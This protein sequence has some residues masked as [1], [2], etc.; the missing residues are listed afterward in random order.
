MR[1]LH[2]LLLCLLVVGA[3]SHD[4]ALDCQDDG[5]FCNG[6]ERF[7]DGACVKVPAAPCDDGVD[8]TQD[9][10][11]EA[12]RTCAHT[13]MGSCAMCRMDDCTPSCT[14]K[15]C[16][17]DG[18][19]GS[20]GS[21]GSGQGCTPMGACARADGLGTCTKPRPLAV[22]LGGNNLQVIQGD[23]TAAVHQSV[24]TCNSTSRAVE[25][26]YS[27]TITEPTGF[28]ATTHD[29]DTVLSLRKEDPA[30]PQSECLDDRAAAT[31]A[32]SD[33]SSPPGDYGS[34]IAVLL[35]PGTYY[36]LVDGFD[37]T[38][39]GPYTLKVKFVAG[40]VPNCDGQYC[41]GSDGCGGSCGSCGAG[42]ACGPDLRCRP[43]PCL[44]S[45]KNQDGSLRVCG[46]DG[47][48][49][50][51]GRCE[52]EK[53]CVPKTGT[54]AAFP[55]CDHMKPTCEPACGK[56]SFCGSDCACHKI[57]DPLPDLVLN[58]QRL[59]DEVLFDYVTVDQNSCSVIEQCVG[60]LGKRRVLRFSVEAINQ[61][62][63]TLTVP[64]PDEHPE[65]FHQ[66]TC[67]GHY[68]FDGFASYGLLDGS[69]K[70][71]VAGR[72]Q[73]YCMEDTR[74]V[75]SGP[76][77]ACRKVY[78]CSMQGI[79]AGWSDLYGN[80]LDCQWLDITGVPAGDYQ[81]RVTLNPNRAFQEISFDNNTAVVPVRIPPQ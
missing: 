80:A 27:F 65:Q 52:A 5:I 63:A 40:C 7:V 67:H 9:V 35:Q 68:H 74:Q 29:Y 39:F 1:R 15:V 60:G 73:A 23:T 4:P 10:C 36:L 69:G 64:P 33:D 51:C 43:S 71:I 18:C 12:T 46:D 58:P 59:K 6:I 38:Q 11:D 26:V 54:C 13:P 79:Q 8:C 24:P 55:V 77:V 20:C 56:G 44:P 21:C 48:L 62:Q 22:R 66:S 57:T 72:K 16:G 42:L 14:G 30:T 28:E 34:R 45:C 41:N 37:D 81:I 32:C 61:G 47:C 76:N 17:S 70:E 78:N 53:L 19:G 25:D 49:G 31:V 2:A 50:L 3:C 75:H